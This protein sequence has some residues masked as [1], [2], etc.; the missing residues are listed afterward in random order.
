MPISYGSLPGPERLQQL[1]CAACSQAS[2]WFIYARAFSSRTAL[3]TDLIF[4]RFF[5]QV[6]SG[7]G[8]RDTPK[9]ERGDK[10]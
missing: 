4:P 9:G 8:E 1:Q 6:Q 3:R 7:R 5:K 10:I 2:N